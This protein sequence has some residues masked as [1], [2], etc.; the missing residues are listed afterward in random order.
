MRIWRPVR[1][2]WAERPSRRS[3]IEEDLGRELQ[4][5][6]DLEAEE[7]RETGLDSAE[8][9]YAATRAFGNEMLIK[10]DIRA[11]WGWASL[12]RLGQDL[13]YG[14]RMLRKAPV[15]TVVAIASL[16]LG[17]GASSAIFTLM[18]AVMLRMM[19]VGEPHRLAQVNRTGPGG[20]GPWVS[21]PTYRLLRQSAGFEDMLATNSVSRWSVV[22]GSGPAEGVSVELV[23][24]NYFSVLRMK[25]I[26]GTLTAD[27]GGAVIS[28]GY[29]NRR[30]AAD[31][32]AL[33]KTLSVNGAAVTIV[34]V[35]PAQFAGVRAGESAEIWLSLL[36]QSQ[37]TGGRNLLN[38]GGHNW[39]RVLGRLAPGASLA[40]AK[41]GAN[42]VFRSNL[43]EQ[44]GGMT[45]ASRDNLLAERIE[46]A[47]GGFGLSNLR[48]RYS[49]P[50]Q[51]LLGAS[52]LALLITCANLA[53]LLLERGAR[54]RK[55]IA[56]RLA[57]GAARQRVVRQ[58]LTESVLL[59]V[60]GGGLGVLFAAWG[61]DALARLALTGARPDALALRP[62]WR[63]VAFTTAVALITGILFGLAPAIQAAQTNL[64]EAIKEAAVRR[65]SRLGSALAISQVSIALTLVSGSGLFARSL[66]NLRS[67][68]PGFD[69]AHVV[70]ARIDTRA[71]G[72]QAA[73]G[74]VFNDLKQRITAL[75]GVLSASLSNRAFFSGG[76]GQRNISVRGYT[77]P[78]GGDLNPFVMDVSERFFETMG[79]RLIAGRPLTSQDEQ[80][81]S[82]RVATVNESFARYYFGAA[83]PI[84]RTFGFGD[85]RANS[86]VEIVGLVADTKDG[87]LR[88]KPRHIV[89]TPLL[90]GDAPVE[91]IMA[92]RAVGNPEAVMASIRAAVEQTHRSISLSSLR[93]MREQVDRSLASERLL[94][95]LSGF[96]AILALLL[97]CLGLYG[98]LAYG[99]RRRTKEF[100]VRI[101]LGAH[102][103]DVERLVVGETTM[104]LVVG[105]VIGAILALST[106]RLAAG[107][108][109]GLSPYDGATLLVSAVAIVVT[110]AMATWGPARSA[111]RADPASAL[112]DE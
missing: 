43:I 40:Q 32:A 8:A 110:A 82:T 52:G 15:F 7:H 91:A 38:Q 2:W 28:Y 3:H 39:L 4:I 37:V 109:F 34:G 73:S 20:A 97:A 84:G 16:A 74:R 42:V 92:V 27:P 48:E 11:M 47:E 80:S 33:G 35:A 58:L 88:E 101:A 93:T 45:G 111:A 86:T 1:R 71:L 36:M 95:T 106:G 29:W 75:P 77:P 23:S 100:A 108:L 10:E 79:V 96:F 87:A 63:V 104:I 46:L 14:T 67:F 61:S 103:S 56:L 31:P 105:L 18:N 59:S 19:P 21:Y 81:R 41:D 51:I 76:E 107:L 44:V 98:V 5:H 69:Q 66:W 78:R 83:S 94:A 55:E 102:A 6:L 64:T 30:F 22:V 12:E 24:P 9:H 62:D 60:A 85:E 70:L 50:L 49:L 57:L 17:I 89:Y 65:R 72:S 99:V 25:P 90:V 53:H 54:R 68:D 112:R 26:L 13:R